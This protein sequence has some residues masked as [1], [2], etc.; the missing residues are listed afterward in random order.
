MTKQSVKEEE[1]LLKPS[2]LHHG[3]NF[4]AVHCGPFSELTQYELKHP[5]LGVLKPGKVFLQE[6]IDSTGM[7]VSLNT[8][9][10]GKVAP[11]SHAHKTNEE[12]YIFVRGEGEMLIDGETIAVAEG[13]CIRLA[14]KAAR[15]MRNSGSEELCFIVI[16]ATENSLGDH[17]FSDGYEVQQEL[18]W[19]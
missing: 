8:F 11:F 10:P 4:K 9:A 18:N 13:S 6:L 14:P 19:K 7:E 2:R 17:T 15:S 12:M 16:Q 5:R 1:T 3:E